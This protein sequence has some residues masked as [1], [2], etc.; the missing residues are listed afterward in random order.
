VIKWIAIVIIILVTL[1]I[2]FS[3]IYTKD[4]SLCR[5]NGLCIIETVSQVIDGDTIHA[6]PY[7]I[8][9]ALTNTPELGED[10][11]SQ[12]SDFTE[13]LCPVGSSI[14]VDQDDMQPFDS[15]GR[16]LGKVTCNGKNLNSELLENDLA[17]ILTKYCSTSEF[18]D[19]PWAKKFGC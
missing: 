4:N 13:N 14:L 19:E 1:V 7:K 8:R 6:N 12:A 16:M 15:Y 17:W 18:S 5:G 2:G 3:I 10:G 9:L 11:F